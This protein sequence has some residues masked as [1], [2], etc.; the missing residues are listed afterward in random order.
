MD[1]LLLVCARSLDACGDLWTGVWP[2]RGCR[3]DVR[4]SQS[5]STAEAIEAVPKTHPPFPLDPCLSAL[6]T[7][8]LAPQSQTAANYGADHD[9]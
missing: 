9:G 1:A 5:R 4:A 3:A 2:V 7:T 8:S 6:T